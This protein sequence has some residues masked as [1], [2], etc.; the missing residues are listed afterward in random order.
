MEA[1]GVWECD[2]LASCEIEAAEAL[3]GLARGAAARGGCCISATRDCFSQ[4]LH[5][6]QAVATQQCC[7][8]TSAHALVTEEANRV[9]PSR[10]RGRAKT[11]GRVR[12]HLSES[13][14]T[15]AEKEAWRV[16]R[17]LANRES[18]RKT[19]R[20]R[21]A[22]HLDLTRKVAFLSDENKN[23]KKEKELAVK[24]YCSLKG[25]NEFLKLQMKNRAEPRGAQKELKSSG[26]E[27]ASSTTQTP[28]C[29]YNQH[30]SVPFFWPSVVPHLNV[31]PLPCVSFP[32]GT[33]SSQLPMRQRKESPSSHHGREITM[34]NT[35]PGNA[36][37][38]IPVPWLLP[39]LN[40]SNAPKLHADASG[41]SKETLSSHQCSLSSP[42]NV[43][44]ADNAHQSLSKPRMSTEASI[45]SRIMPVVCPHGAEWTFPEDRG[46]HLK[47]NVLVTEPLGCVRPVECPR[48][49]R[50]PRAD[51]VNDLRNISVSKTPHSLLKKNQEFLSF[52]QKKSENIYA[53]INARKRRKELMQMKNNINCRHFR[54]HSTGS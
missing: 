45:S 37:F 3:T 25:R 32:D 36:L 41:A 31:F 43:L 21:R 19:I 5:Q 29:L 14:T 8:S 48:S 27:L 26:M 51:D 34:G 49:I 30:S 54:M 6:N 1:S 16:R 46:C 13:S 11:T 52:K 24:N 18:A 7:G 44:H 12:Q 47:G 38:V 17:V 50:R 53:A 39:V 28:T 23:L 9:A 22:M 4:S 42:L 2:R 35:K 33:C 10:L 15:Q 20:R 40:H